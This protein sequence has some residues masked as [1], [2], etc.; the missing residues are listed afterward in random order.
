MF[1][2]MF[3]ALLAD[4]PGIRAQ[5]RGAA[6]PPI[7][8]VTFEDAVRRALEKN[9]TVAEAA[10][11]ILRAEGL[12]QQ[13]RA[14]TRPALS[15]NVSN[16]VLNSA[17][18]F[19]GAVVQPRDQVFFNANLSAPVLAASQ[20]A[21]AS[22]ARD[23]IEVARLSSS[24][25]RRQIAAAAAQAYLAVISQT[26]Q[27]EVNQR[28]RESAQSHLDYAERRLAAGAGSRL[29][30]LRAAQE[31]SGDEARLENARL[32]V[33][34]AQ[35]ALGVLMAAGG[36]VDAD[37]EPV[38]DVP[39]AAPALVAGE[40]WMADRTDLKLLTA[41]QTAAERVV[42]DSPK[43]WFPTASVSF[44]PQFVAPSGAFTPSSTWRLTISGSQPIFD[45]GQRRAL[46]R[47]REA[48]AESSRLSLASAQIQARSEVRLADEAIR[49]ADRALASLRLS[50]QQAADVLTITNTAFEAGATTNLEVIDAQR[51]ARDAD[52]A[53][54][55]AA[56]VLQ[57]AKL[58]LLTALG[59]FP[60]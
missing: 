13:A 51:S 43:D 21:A 8:R 33:R 7:E 45:G 32:A 4:R 58:D 52:S 44:D 24:D 49:S 12:L 15:G 40:T 20:W 19:G 53:V 46:V 10:T 38:F 37:G 1:L 30:Q 3:A 54:A 25:V 29:N 41:A 42:K 59:R 23:Q 35:E 57:R 9:P 31:V 39:G 55:I 17:Q 60:R 22:Q 26:R 48:A 18:G 36:P 6:E 56:D 50:A 11:A 47:L 2:L 14:A 5:V 16:T 28:A 34:R 27:V